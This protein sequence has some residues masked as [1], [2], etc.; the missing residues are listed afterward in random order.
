MKK[1]YVLTLFSPSAELTPISN[2]HAA[3][4]GL[5]EDN[6]KNIPPNKLG[7]KIHSNEH[8]KLNQFD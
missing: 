2:V 8:L 5:P 7:T 6:E 4:N 3:R 1:K